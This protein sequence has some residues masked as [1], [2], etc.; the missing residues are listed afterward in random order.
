ME[1]FKESPIHTGMHWMDGLH[2]S[3]ELQS[4]NLDDPLVP[5]ASAAYFPNVGGAKI[6]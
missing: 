6:D 5:F 4:A 2:P 3:G 1:F